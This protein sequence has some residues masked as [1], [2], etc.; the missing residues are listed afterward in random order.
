MRCD[1]VAARATSS[2]WIILAT[3][4]LLCPPP[5]ATADGGGGALPLQQAPVSSAGGNYER[6]SNYV[7]MPGAPIK[8]IGSASTS[9][10]QQQQQ[11]HQAPPSMIR[12]P[13]GGNSEINEI[14]N[15]RRSDD[16]ESDQDREVVVLL[17]EITEIANWA[18]TTTDTFDG[19]GHG[20][21]EEGGGR[22]SSSNS[23]SSHSL[24]VIDNSNNNNNN[25]NI[26]QRMRLQVTANYDPRADHLVDDREDEELSTFNA[27][28]I[29][30]FNQRNQLLGSRALQPPPSPQERIAGGDGDR[31][32]SQQVATAIMGGY[33]SLGIG[34]GIRGQGEQ[35]KQQQQQQEKQRP[36]P[37]MVPMTEDEIDDERIFYD[38]VD[39]KHLIS[40]LGSSRLASGRGGLLVGLSMQRSESAA[41]APGGVGGGGAAAAA[42]TG[43]KAGKGQ[44]SCC[45]E[46]WFGL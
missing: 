37:A 6:D 7:V 1:G 13:G 39:S 24:R 31:A 3:A 42:A 28:A 41:A 5:L 18:D 46:L 27:F 38:I 25:D 34:G 43:A 9:S 8:T 45:V 19:G 21:E 10:P 23:R 22:S 11:Q 15:E 26:D 29:G 17:N 36:P 33:A 16:D 32:Q 12:R 2:I 44:K 40:R 35:Q 20:E 30:T 14:N 4:C